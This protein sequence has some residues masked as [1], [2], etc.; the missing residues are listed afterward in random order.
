MGNDAIVIQEPQDAA[1]QLVLLFHGY[2]ANAQNLL[3]LGQRIAQAFPKALV[4]SV[5]APEPSGNPGGHQWFS[6]AGITEDNRQE[7]VDACM[8]DFVACIGH[9]QARSGVGSAAT[10]L[11]GF[12]QGAIMALES[13]KLRPAP[14]SRVVAIAGR[15]ASLPKTVD[16]EGTIH[17]LH[18]K[19]DEVIAYQYTV[20]AAHYLRDNGADITAEV[21]P[22]VGH[23]IPAE[24]A[25]LAAQKLS[26]HISHKLWTQAIQSAQTGGE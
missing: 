1:A 10:A 6:V 19:E 16:F 2:G 9:W 25:E 20:E 23:A 15:F 14:A 22:Y 21:L 12:S 3:P 8:G 13:T 24:F 7:R 18:G 4:V 5:N 11:V 17:F 26:N